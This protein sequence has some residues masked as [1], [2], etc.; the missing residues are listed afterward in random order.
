[1]ELEDGKAKFDDIKFFGGEGANKWYNVI[2]AEGRNRLVRRLW[3][4]QE[5]VVSRLMRVRYGPVVLPERLKAR[6]FYELTDKELELLFEFAGMASEKPAIN[7][8]PESKAH[9]SGKR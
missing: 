5:V 9:K 8:K 6:T 3:E 1:M 2:V 4:S 7:A